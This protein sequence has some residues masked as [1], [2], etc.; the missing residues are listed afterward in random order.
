MDC[1]VRIPVWRYFNVVCRREGRDL[2]SFRNAARERRVALQY[3]YGIGGDQIARPPS[4]E[5]VLT[6]G[7]GDVLLTPYLGAAREIVWFHRLLE[8]ER[9]VLLHQ[10]PKADRRHFASIR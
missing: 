5:L 2:P 6:R 4:R 10:P 9:V 7:D 8:P 1:H 3:V